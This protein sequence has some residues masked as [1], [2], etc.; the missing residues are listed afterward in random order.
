MDCIGREAMGR[1]GDPGSARASWGCGGRAGPG[2][3]Q[4]MEGVWPTGGG[5][6]KWTS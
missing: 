6:G 4:C 5:E 3:W 2:G 1:K